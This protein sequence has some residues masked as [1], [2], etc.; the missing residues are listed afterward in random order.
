MRA[1]CERILRA[2][3]KYRF[4]L[5]KHISY[6]FWHTYKPKFSIPKGMT[7]GVV[8]MQKS[9]GDKRKKTQPQKKEAVMKSIKGAIFGLIITVVCVLVFAVI[10][11][12]AGLGDE[13]ISAV[14]QAIKVVSIFIAAFIA[15]RNLPEGHLMAGMMSGA[16]YVV[17]GYL[18]FSLI[19]GQFGDILLMFA[20]LAM[21]VVIGMLTAMIFGKLRKQPKQPVKGAKK[22]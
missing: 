7:K 4:F 15:S 18:T 8:D 3:E 1:I 14:N 22:A 13:A 6:Y 20:D 12:Q 19:E 10:V 16:M 5:E 17:L 11:K 9:R 2:K 21:G